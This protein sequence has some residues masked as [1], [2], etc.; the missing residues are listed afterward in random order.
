MNNIQLI[1]QYKIWLLASDRSDATVRL[2]LRDIRKLA[3]QHELTTIT[4]DELTEI[5]AAHRHH[6]PETRKSL[7]GSWRLFFTWA[8]RRGH[9]PDNP[10]TQL[11]KIR[12]PAPSPRV[13]PDDDIRQAL[14]RATPQQRAL[15]LLA[16][17]GWMRLSEIASLHTNNRHGQELHIIGKGRKPRIIAM[18]AE[19]ATA[20]DTLE[21]EQGPGYY[22]PRRIQRG[23]LPH[24]HPV[25]V[26]KIITRVTG[27]NPHSLR[28]AGAT[29]AW[30]QT[31][32]LRAI[33]AMLGH[34]SLVTTQRYVHITG[35]DLATVAAAS[36]LSLTPA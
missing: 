33:Q 5:L 1:D 14:T 34:A 4:E 3:E 15:I 30:K 26:N 19:V 8:H 7:T 35:D 21:H 20:L 23:N 18:N 29:A 10:T 36:R 27:W 16:R 6:A 22:F 12:I 2:R 24:L 17:G 25:S 31:H 9:R 32:D 13:A 11:Q 28:H